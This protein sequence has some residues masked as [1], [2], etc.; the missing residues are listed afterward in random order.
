MD[1]PASALGQDVG[2]KA[3]RRAGQ[4]RSRRP[5]PK[6]VVMSPFGIAGQQA[7]KARAADQSQMRRHDPARMFASA[8]SLPLGAGGRNRGSIK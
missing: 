1:M 7:A 8:L 4:D 6:G 3:V 2:G 5:A